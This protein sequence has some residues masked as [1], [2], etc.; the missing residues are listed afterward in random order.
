MPVPKHINKVT[1]QISSL[2]W[3]LIILFH[4][5]WKKDKQIL[6]GIKMHQICI[7]NDE[8]TPWQELEILSPS[9]LIIKN[10]FTMES[11]IISSVLS[12]IRVW[13]LVTHEPQHARS[14]CPSPT[15]G[16][17]PNSCPLSRWC[18][19]TISSSVVPFS[20]CSQ[21]FPAS[22]FFQISQLFTSGGLSI[23]VSASTSVLPMTIQA[24][25]P[26]GLK[27]WISLQ[28]K[29]LSRVFS[30]ITVQNHQFFGTQLSL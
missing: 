28:S 17:Y 8:M 25:F 12:L 11:S 18:H 15:P 27:G 19:P 22:G 4:K 20:S 24:W 30:N 5:H 13:P 16:V 9:P 23:G 21:S 10:L 3:V 1:T 26:L 2:K 29:G 7:M 6:A 14:P